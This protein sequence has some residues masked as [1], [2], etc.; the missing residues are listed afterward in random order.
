MPRSGTGVLWRMGDLQAG[1]VPRQSSTMPL[2]P[3]RTKG[4]IE[5]PSSTPP[6]HGYK[7]PN[8]APLPEYPFAPNSLFLTVV[9]GILIG[10]SEGEKKM[11]KY[12]T[13]F[14]I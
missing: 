10:F 3:Q 4:S 14:A 8:S 7:T 12:R 6:Q 13:G 1:E 2:L 9:T 5:G 11:H